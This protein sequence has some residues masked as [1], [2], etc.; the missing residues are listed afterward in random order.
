MNRIAD[1]KVSWPWLQYQTNTIRYRM[2]IL[3]TISKVFLTFDIEGHVITCRIRYRIRY[4]IHPMS[5]TAERNLLRKLSLSRLH[6]AC[7]DEFQRHVP[8]IPAPAFWHIIQELC[9]GSR[10]GS[11][12]LPSRNIL[13]HVIN[14]VDCQSPFRVIAV[15][16]RRA[17]NTGSCVGTKKY[18]VASISDTISGTIM[19]TLQ[20]DHFCTVDICFG[21]DKSRWYWVQFSISTLF[22]RLICIQYRSF[23]SIS[24]EISCCNIGM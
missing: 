11:K 17:W 3:Y 23:D 15:N 19:R 2:L 6:H 9:S 12:E 8:W 10:S 22:V 20:N 24:G 16:R 14:H 7:A 13:V 4:N 1:V 18:I 21:I 5:F